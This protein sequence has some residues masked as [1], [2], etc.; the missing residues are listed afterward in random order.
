MKDL[1]PSCPKERQRKIIE[2]MRSILREIH[3]AALDEKDP[4]IAE[5]MRREYQEGL[6]ILNVMEAMAAK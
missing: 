3:G 1:F 5:R 2:A 6:A 4:A